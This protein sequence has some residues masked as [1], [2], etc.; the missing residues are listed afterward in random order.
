[1]F[2][3]IAGLSKCETFPVPSEPGTYEVALKNSTDVISDIREIEVKSGNLITFIQ[4]DKP[5]YRPGESGSH[6]VIS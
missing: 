2:Y 3:A 6:T 1:M 4:T 5:I